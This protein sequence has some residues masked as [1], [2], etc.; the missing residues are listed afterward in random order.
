MVVCLARWVLT[1]G[2]YINLLVGWLIGLAYVG[3]RVGGLVGLLGNW[4]F[5]CLF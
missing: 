2:K 5:V 4:L 1:D 3:L